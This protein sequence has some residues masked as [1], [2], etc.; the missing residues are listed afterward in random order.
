MSINLC[1]C[2]SSSFFVVVVAPLAWN[3]SSFRDLFA[4]VFVHGRATFHLCINTYTKYFNNV[5][6]YPVMMMQ[7]RMTYNIIL[8]LCC[9]NIIS[10]FI[11]VI[12][13]IN[14]K[15]IKYDSFDSIRKI[16]DRQNSNS[17]R[18]T[19]YSKLKVFSWVF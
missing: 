3:K 11:A 16:A 14:M 2:L 10:R 18:W 5:L 7:C 17:L 9:W 4:C 6:S 19:Q 1:W 15:L 13:L 12:N 8:L